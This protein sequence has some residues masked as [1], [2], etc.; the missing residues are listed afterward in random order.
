MTPGPARLCR[1]SEAGC[2]PSSRL[3]L[4]GL[5]PGPTVPSGLRLRPRRGVLLPGGLPGHCGAA[6]PDAGSHLD[7]GLSGR[8]ESEAWPAHTKAA[9]VRDTEPGLRSVPSTLIPRPSLAGGRPWHGKEG[10]REVGL[11]T[12]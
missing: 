11:W 7:V 8:T 5:S 3:G 9:A 6:V 1:R 12:S 2:R 10:R 4:T